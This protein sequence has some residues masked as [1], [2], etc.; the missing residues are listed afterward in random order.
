MSQKP[1][2]YQLEQYY[3]FWIR[4]LETTDIAQEMNVSPEYIKQHEAV[5]FEFCRQTARI[6]LQESLAGNKEVV[7]IELSPKR[8]KILIDLYSSGFPLNRIADYL[9]V[10]TITITEFWFKDDPTLKI[11]CEAAATKSDHDVLKALKKRAIGFRFKSKSVTTTKIKS[12]I[13]STVETERIQVITPSVNAQILWLIN[14]L[15]WVTGN[16][17][18]PK[19]AD[20]EKTEYDIHEKLY[21]EDAID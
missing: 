15:G 8:K 1:P 5:F 21:D 20:A 10:P 4:G 14:R 2:K 18:L 13:V 17:G 19:S 7:K 3:N 16:E 12:T 11:Q 6:E 9:N